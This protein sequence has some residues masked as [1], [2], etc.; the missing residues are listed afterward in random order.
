MNR[1]IIRYALVLIAAFMFAGLGGWYFFLNQQTQTITATDTSRG[2]GTSDSSFAS[3]VGNTYDNIVSGITTLIGGNGTSTVETNNGAPPQLWKITKTPVAGMAFVDNAASTKLY[4]AESSTGYILTADPGTGAIARITNKLFPKTYEVVFGRGGS[5]VL[6]SIDEEGVITNFSGTLS[7]VGTTTSEVKAG[8]ITFT[9]KNLERNIQGIV[10]APYTREILYVR[11]SPSGGALGVRSSWDGTKQK[12]V[13]SSPL[14]GWEPVSLLDGA[15]FFVLRPADNVPGF[16]YKLGSDGS[17]SKEVGDVPG[18]TFLPNASSTAILYG[19]SANG[20]LALFARVRSDATAFS[21]PIRTVADKCV[22]STE[23]T[24]PTQSTTTP[25]VSTKKPVPVVKPLVAYC[26]V[27]QFI[28]SN[29]FLND[30]YRGAI[31][32]SDS[33]WRVDV[34]AG[35]V[36]LLLSPSPSETIDV[37][38]PAMDDSGRYIAFTNARDKTLWI[39]RIAK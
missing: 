17:L 32:T 37:E 34:S 36:E 7:R 22:W 10:S 2:L 25:K 11:R 19:A 28:V 23:V 5:V 1:N 30:W 24:S 26:A 38:D 13:F 9:G 6:R 29:T 8:D 3:A 14:S 39:L 27:P 21:L 16:A 35:T 12:T 33:W 18:L 4:F 31:H 20:E 15:T